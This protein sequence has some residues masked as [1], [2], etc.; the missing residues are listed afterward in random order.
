LSNQLS[1]EDEEGEYERSEFEEEEEDLELKA[2]KRYLE[3][4]EARREAK[5]KKLER[6]AKKLREKAFKDWPNKELLLLDFLAQ[7]YRHLFAK[8]SGYAELCKAHLLIC[9]LPQYHTLLEFEHIRKFSRDANGC[10]VVF[11]PWD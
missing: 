8:L 4:F 3:G 1:D 2:E 9:P 11:T 6:I 5:E 10:V 7:D